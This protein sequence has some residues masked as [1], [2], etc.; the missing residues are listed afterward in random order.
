MKSLLGKAEAG[1]PSFRVQTSLRRGAS[2]A[3]AIPAQ[4]S[5]Y[6]AK[7]VQQN[8][9][10]P[11]FGGEKEGPTP[12][13]WEGEAGSGKYSG[14]RHLTPTLSTPRGGEGNCESPSVQ[15]EHEQ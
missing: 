13:A 1:V 7:I 6:T 4:I 10:S 12:E 14:I 8:Q 15:R 2:S 9:P 5:K 3:R 11:P